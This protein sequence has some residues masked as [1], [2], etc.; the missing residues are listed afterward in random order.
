MY[1]KPKYEL[2]IFDWDGCLF[3]SNLVLLTIIKEEL[4]RQGILVDDDVVISKIFGNWAYGLAKLGVRDPGSTLNAI[5]LELSKRLYG[6]KLNSGVRGVLGKLKRAGVKLVVS[7]P[8]DVELVAPHIERFGL[9]KYFTA[10]LS[11]KDFKLEKTN[12]EVML[13]V[14]KELGVINSKVLL[15]GNSAKDVMAAKNAGFKI[16]V[17]YPKENHKIYNKK[18]IEKAKPNYIV[19]KLSSIEPIVLG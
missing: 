3:Q 16:A 2:V 17:F 4:A 6:A 7:A 19:E 11:N 9:R 18:E 15:V 12:P 10:V 8:A 1:K 13:S 5:F 14:A